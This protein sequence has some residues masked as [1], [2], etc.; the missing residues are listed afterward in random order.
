MALFF[1]SLRRRT[2][3][4]ICSCG[5][6]N[7][8]WNFCF[9]VKWKNPFLTAALTKLLFGAIHGPQFSKRVENLKNVVVRA[10]FGEF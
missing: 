2:A 4:N 7:D 3:K 10:T 8:A 9:V 1:S 6:N 5:L